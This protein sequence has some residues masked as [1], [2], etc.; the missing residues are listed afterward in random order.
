MRSV[1]FGS[2]QKMRNAWSK[3]GR[4]SSLESSTAD[5]VQYQSSRRSAPA[6]SSARTQSSTRSGPILPGAPAVSRAG[7]MSGGRRG[8]RLGDQARRL[9]ARDALDVVAVLEEHAER[10]VHRLRV[11]RDLVEGDQAVR[12]IDRLGDAGQLEEIR[13]PQP[14]HEGDDLS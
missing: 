11:E 12:P 13:L 5:M 7:I 10:V 2:R 6:I 3:I 14:L 9:L 8:F 1:R 4:C